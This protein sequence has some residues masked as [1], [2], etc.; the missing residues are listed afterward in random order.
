M[1]PEPLFPELSSIHELES[2]CSSSSGCEDKPC[3]TSVTV[4]QS[5]KLITQPPPAGAEPVVDSNVDEGVLT[6]KLSHHAPN[7]LLGAKVGSKQQIQREET[8]PTVTS[9][10]W[11]SSRKVWRLKQ[12]LHFESDSLQGATPHASRERRPHASRS[13]RRR[14]TM[15]DGKRM[16]LDCSALP[17]LSVPARPSRAGRLRAK[18]VSQKQKLND[19]RSRARRM[20]ATAMKKGTLRNR[21]SMK[22]FICRHFKI[23]CENFGN[24]S[25][26]SACERHQ[27]T[28]LCNRREILRDSPKALAQIEE[29]IWSKNEKITS[30]CRI[31]TNCRRQYRHPGLC[32]LSSM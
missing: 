13:E 3:P 18:T 21:S 6:P 12:T 4:T 9:Q 29:L 23:K 22:C 7:R 30:T 14:A 28:H 15:G 20:L 8:P 17:L 5:P 1:P 11:F 31:N 2:V 27:H 16:N 25:S 32:D 26:C 19:G 24:G 10:G